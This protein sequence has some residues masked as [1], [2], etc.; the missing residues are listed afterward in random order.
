MSYYILDGQR[1]VPCDL[2]EWSEW[3][4]GQDTRNIMRDD[5]ECEY[6]KNGSMTT[7]DV[8]VVTT[9]IGTGNRSELFELTVTGG[10]LHRF[11]MY[12]G[13]FRDAWW[14]HYYIGQLIRPFE[15]GE[16]IF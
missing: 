3:F 15:L 5:F 9:F 10:P 2:P 16:K 6:M 7:A 13:E 14:N 1:I 4:R 11:G 12:A 8:R